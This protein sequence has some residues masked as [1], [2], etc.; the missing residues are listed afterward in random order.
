MQCGSR[1][2]I[3]YVQYQH[4]DENFHKQLHKRFKWCFAEMQATSFRFSSVSS[5]FCQASHQVIM[6]RLPPSCVITMPSLQSIIFSKPS[7]SACCRRIPQLSLVS[8]K[9]CM[10]Q[11][12][13]LKH[14]FHLLP[15]TKT[16]QC[17]DMVHLPAVCNRQWSWNSSKARRTCALLKFS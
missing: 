17:L 8:A 5:T 15:V 10:L 6:L 16:S 4:S 14:D 12:L 9:S 13:T 7:S 3:Y 11:K 1:K 2:V